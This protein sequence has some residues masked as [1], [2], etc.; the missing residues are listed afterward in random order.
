[1]IKA[2]EIFQKGVQDGLYAR[3]FKSD[4]DKSYFEIDLHFLSVGAAITSILWWFDEIVIPHFTT[5]R[6]NSKTIHIITG[7]GKSRMENIVKKENNYAK[8]GIAKHVRKVL[9][10]LNLKEIPQHNMG[11]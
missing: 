10:L 2:K 9:D 1:M 6:A 3:L 11:M 7:Y 5:A 8:Q 4:D